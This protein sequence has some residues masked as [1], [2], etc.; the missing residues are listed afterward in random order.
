[1]SQMTQIQK[2]QELSVHELHE[3]REGEAQFLAVSQFA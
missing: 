3:L 2:R 1:M